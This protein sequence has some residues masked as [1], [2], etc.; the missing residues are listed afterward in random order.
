MWM[1]RPLRPKLSTQYLRAV[2]KGM[3][4]LNRMLAKVH[5]TLNLGMCRSCMRFRGRSGLQ[6]QILL[7]TIPRNSE[8]AASGGAGL[9][10]KV[11]AG[12]FRLP[13]TPWIALFCTPQ[14][15]Y[16]GV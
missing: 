10:G 5:E 13:F 4:R 11:G 15:G 8:I 1:A 12:V 2:T 7:Y 6:R 3:T 14:R 9:T 16:T